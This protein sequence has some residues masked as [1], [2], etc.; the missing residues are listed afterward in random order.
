MVMHSKYL[1]YLAL[2]MG[3]VTSVFFTL[4]LIVEGFTKLLQGKFNVIP[5]LMMMI[6]EVTGFIWAVSKPVKGS[7]VMIVSGLTIIIYLMVLG[8]IS[9]I[10]MSLLFGLPFVM[11]GLLLYFISKH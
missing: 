10:M 6:V 8:G 11:P 9:E 5:I 1:R 7:I 3:F 4:F 2:S